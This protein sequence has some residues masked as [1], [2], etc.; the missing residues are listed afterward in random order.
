M[1]KSDVLIKWTGSKRS[2]AK[3]IIEYFPKY[4]DNYFE[5]FAGSCSVLWDLLNNKDISVNHY[6]CSDINPDLIFLWNEIKEHPEMVISTYETLWNSLNSI[7]EQ[8]KRNDLW[9]D[10]RNEFNKNRNPYLFLFLNRTCYN[11]LIRYNNSG[12]F[13]TSYHFSRKGIDPKSLHDIIFKWNKILVEKNV[14]FNHGD[15]LDII[16]KTNDFMYCD[17]PYSKSD[18]MYYGK[19]NY[20]EF[21]LYLNNLE[22]KWILSFDGF[23][24]EINNI[25]DIPKDLYKKH[26]LIDSGISSFSK[27]KGNNVSVKESIYL[28]YE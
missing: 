21:F 9:Y 25:Y 15:Y 1:N 11:G 26:L 7:E 23:Q 14:I 20:N 12:E 18:S 6:I 4:I 2:Q 17:P 16:T 24:N 28:N 13:N 3:D 10:I 5:P 27:L 19:I 22:C 8:E